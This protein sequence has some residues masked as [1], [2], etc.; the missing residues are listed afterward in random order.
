MEKATSKRGAMKRK[1]TDPSLGGSSGREQRHKAWISRYHGGARVGSWRPVQLNRCG[2]KRWLANLDCQLRLQVATS[3]SGWKY[4]QYDASLPCW[5]HWSRWPWCGVA[6][7]L[8]SDGL[9]ASSALLHLYDCNNTRFDDFS[10]GANNDLKVTLKACGLFSFW[11]VCMISWNLPYGH[12]QDEQ[13]RRQLRECMAHV[14]ETETFE[15]CVLFKEWSAQML[16]EWINNGNELPRVKSAEEELWD[17][18]VARNPFARCGRR[19]RRR[20]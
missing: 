16:G 4:F 19:A 13:R 6:M 3:P 9:A 5:S 2:A 10:H 15:S 18:L 1:A 12:D 17:A 8:G 11:L 14:Y 20:G 7:D